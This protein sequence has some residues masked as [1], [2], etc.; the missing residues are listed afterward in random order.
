MARELNDTPSAPGKHVEG[1]RKP[2]CLGHEGCDADRLRRYEETDGIEKTIVSS[3]I[4]VMILREEN[5][6]TDAW[7]RFSMNLRA[8]RLYAVTRAVC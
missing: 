7:V 3:S 5:R 8:A 4:F 6:K 2:P 1:L